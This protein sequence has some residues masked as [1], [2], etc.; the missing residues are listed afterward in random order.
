MPGLPPNNRLTP[1][2]DNR[3][4]CTN[5]ITA[6]CGRHGE[7]SALSKSRSGYQSRQQP[8]QADGSSRA[9]GRSRR[10]LPMHLVHVQCLHLPDEVGQ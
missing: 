10:E 7:A 3:E 5:P 9:L 4:R 8:Q 1:H 6:E 2:C